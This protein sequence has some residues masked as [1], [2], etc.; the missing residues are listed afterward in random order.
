MKVKKFK[1]SEKGF[2]IALALMMLVAMS[3]MGVTLVLVSAKDHKENAEKD[4]NQQ[5]FYAAETGIIEARKWLENQ[6]NL[7]SN[8]VSVSNLKF[9]KTSF[10]N[11]STVKFI[12]NSNSGAHIGINT[13]DNI[14]T[15]TE[16]AE[17]KRLK[18]FSYEYFITYTP[19]ANGDTTEKESRDTK[20][21]TVG[22]S[23]AEETA[24][25]EGAGTS[26]GT[27]Y[28]IFSCGCNQKPNDCEVGKNT[29][30]KLIADVMLI[31]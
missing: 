17:T 14:I 1:K 4:S 23:V 11:L 5:A 22:T 24:Y 18:R 7:H 13:L 15:T 12:N 31:Q 2:A 9:C 8:D 25:K 6:T 28:T 29:V 16:V 26:K 19:K 20:G 27:Y 3:L 10:F 30:V 21:T